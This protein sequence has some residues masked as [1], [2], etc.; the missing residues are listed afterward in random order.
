MRWDRTSGMGF[1]VGFI[2]DSGKRG[3]LNLG[4]G[5]TGLHV[6]EPYAGGRAFR[7]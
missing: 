2:A 3:A 4:G 6:L 7:L 5:Q 1:G